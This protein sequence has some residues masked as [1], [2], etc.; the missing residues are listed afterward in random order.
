MLKD[1]FLDKSRK[2]RKNCK[3]KQRLTSDPNKNIKSIE[4]EMKFE[5]TDCQDERFEPHTTSPLV[6]GNPNY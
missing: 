2:F 4:A 3:N 5:T 1:K 6:Q